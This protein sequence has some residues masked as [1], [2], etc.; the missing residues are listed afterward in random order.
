MISFSGNRLNEKRRSFAYN[1]E[2][3]VVGLEEDIEALLSRLI[4]G[5]C[6]RSVISIMGMAGLGKTTLAKKVYLSCDI[7]KH[8]DYCAWVYV[9]Q[10]YRAGDILLELGKKVMGFAK[11]GVGEMNGE[12]LR[13]SLRIFL[14]DKRYLNVLD[15]IWKHEHWDDLRPAFPE[16]NNG[17]RIILTTRFK[18]IALYADMRDP[19]HELHF[20]DHDRSWELF[21]KKLCVEWVSS[22]RLPPWSQELGKEIVQRCG[23]LPLAIVVLAGL[24]SRKEAVFSEWLKVSQSVNWQLKQ[25]LPQCEEILALSY[26][27]LP[28]YLKPCF[29]YLGLFPEDFEIPARRIA[30]LWVAEGF[31]QPR[32]Q[33]QIEDVA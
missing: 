6:R 5:D 13:D 18:D 3:D 8:F 26:A 9:S 31:V 2:D 23:G 14:S 21:S 16:M 27:D 15:D 22:S 10:E 11:E 25:E 17:S 4:H 33:E 32:G 28:Y 29:L 19:P 24:L 7:N 12:D 20:L 30:L 1:N